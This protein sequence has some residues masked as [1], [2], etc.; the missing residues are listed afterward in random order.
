ML[1]EQSRIY[2]G[3]IDQNNAIIGE[4][5]HRQNIPNIRSQFSCFVDGNSKKEDQSAAWACVFLTLM[6]FL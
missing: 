4:W 2:D 1:E 6:E 5:V 3:G